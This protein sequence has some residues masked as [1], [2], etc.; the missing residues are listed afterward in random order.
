LS[1]NTAS[2]E[3]AT[4]IERILAEEGGEYDILPDELEEIHPKLVVPP[5]PHPVITCIAVLVAD[6]VNKPKFPLLLPG[7]G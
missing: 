7:F 1:E 2:D 4:C 5:P 3:E 6:C